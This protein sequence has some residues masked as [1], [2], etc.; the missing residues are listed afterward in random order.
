MYIPEI[1]TST[2]PYRFH[3][4]YPTVFLFAMKISSGP[5]TVPEKISAFLTKKSEK[6]ANRTAP[7][8]VQFSVLEPLILVN[9]KSYRVENWNVVYF[10]WRMLRNRKRYYF[11]YTVVS[12][13]FIFE[14]RNL[15]YLVKCDL[16]NPSNVLPKCNPTDCH[17]Y[18]L[19]LRVS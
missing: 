1:L 18:S 10:T 6:L 12:S 4:L 13:F 7:K 14:I 15:I 9:R 2:V 3:L 8:N 11:K 19:A 16:K 17:D 5:N